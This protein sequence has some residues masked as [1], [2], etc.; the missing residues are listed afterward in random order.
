M[1]KSL[2]Q[3]LTTAMTDDPDSLIE[4]AREL[5]QEE[6]LRKLLIQSGRLPLYDALRDEFPDAVDCGENADWVERCF[7]LGNKQPNV[8][9]GGV[10]VYDEGDNVVMLMRSYPSLEDDSGNTVR[11]EVETFNCGDFATAI[12]RINEE[13]K[14][15]TVTALSSLI[16]KDSR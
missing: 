7:C 11:V 15:P 5:G 14:A 16:F 12:R 13:R 2:I 8:I 9:D 6:V 4:A 1:H 10:Y 3:A